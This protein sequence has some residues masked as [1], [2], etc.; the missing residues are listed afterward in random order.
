ML[1]AYLRFVIKN[2]RIKWPISLRD[3]CCVLVKVQVIFCSLKIIRQKSDFVTLGRKDELAGGKM[4]GFKGVWDMDRINWNFLATTFK[5][6]FTLLTFYQIKTFPT[7]LKQTEYYLLTT[8]SAF[9]FYAVKAWNFC[10][11]MCF[12]R[13]ISLCS[14]YRIACIQ[15]SQALFSIQGGKNE[16]DYLSFMHWNTLKCL[17]C[18]NWG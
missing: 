4:S 1:Q 11:K 13:S 3:S 8:E 2:N 5:A 15:A 7:S 9:V 16:L 18:K 6:S 12:F 10:L 14:L 17:Q